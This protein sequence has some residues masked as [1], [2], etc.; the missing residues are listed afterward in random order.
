MNFCNKRP[1]QYD[2]ILGE[3]ME[4]FGTKSPIS[5][6]MEYMQYSKSR[7]NF[8]EVAPPEGPDHKPV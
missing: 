7:V 2:N 6:L 8:I 3:M 4:L 1:E 5:M